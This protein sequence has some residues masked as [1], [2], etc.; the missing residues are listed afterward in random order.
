MNLYLSWREISI[1]FIMISPTEACRY[2]QQ[3]LP[4]ISTELPADGNMYVTLQAFRE[5]ACKN[6]LEHN[7]N[8]LQQCF[9]L[10]AA[11][12]EKG[13]NTVKSA[14]ENVF[15]YSFSRLFA[16]AAEDRQKVKNLIPATLLALYMNQV[17]HRGY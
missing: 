4:D 16:L 1:P 10:A 17:M 7:Y 5:Y 12:Y 3:Q 14:V 9:S 15:V 6:A 11:L 13:S 2:V 8:N